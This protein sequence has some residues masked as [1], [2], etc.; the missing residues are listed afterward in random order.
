MND[1]V[2]SIHGRDIG[3][4]AERG[5]IVR[6]GVIRSPGNAQLS[7]PDGILIGGERSF[8]FQPAVPRIA[9]IGDS[10]F[11]QAVNVTA[12]NS[13]TYN[14]GVNFW[15]EFLT[16]G[17]VYCPPDLTFATAGYTTTQILDE[18]YPLCLASRAEIVC[19]LC[20][21]N[22]S[23]AGWSGTTRTNIEVMV[24]GFLA[25]GKVVI[26]IPELPRDTSYLHSGNNLK[27]FTSYQLWLRDR[28]SATRG[29]YIADPWYLV[30]DMTTTDNRWK[31]G[32]STDGIH[33]S[34]A[35]GYYVAQPVVDIINALY[36]PTQ[37]ALTP[38]QADIYD[39]T[40]TP[41]GN[42]FSN[43]M[44]T[45]TGGTNG[46]NNSGSLATG[47]VLAGATAGEFTSVNSKVTSA[48]NGRPMQQ[49]V[50]SSASPNASQ[51]IHNLTATMTAGNFSA[52]DIIEASCELEIDAGLVGSNLPQFRFQYT[53][54]GVGKTASAGMQSG[55][56]TFAGAVRGLMRTPRIVIPPGV[57]TNPYIQLIT[58]SQSGAT[59]AITY[60]FGA[61][62]V[63]KV[64]SLV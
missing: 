19:L 37:S 14:R 31:S 35:G 3:L 12:N 59:A 61:I 62:S 10:R 58:T 60:R 21:T 45:G 40:Y 16:Y 25:A 38:S 23:L 1:I 55:S 49:F 24:S 57:L 33:L 54:D 7:F 2:T 11:A 15:V 53:I 64:S 6:S 50:V 18:W 9:F 52:G 22:D 43:G 20:G 28:F 46:T 13:E 26:I 34:T 48:F 51:R 42:L 30:H 63:R 8:A 29:V 44:V 17:R 32:Y 39:A 5:L 56:N 36:P 47:F 4:D 27:G 41:N